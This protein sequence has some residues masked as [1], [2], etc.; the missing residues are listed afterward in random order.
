MGQGDRIEFSSG[1][2]LIEILRIDVLSPFHLKRFGVLT[3]SLG[4]IEPFV[5]KRAA[6]TA[7]DPS[8]DLVANR[9]FHHSPR[10]RR[11]K[12]HRLLCT[13]Q[14]LKLWMNRVVKIPK[15]FAAMSNQWTR[16]RLPGFF[17]D[18]NWTGNEKLVVRMHELNIRHSA[19]L[20]K[21]SARQALNFQ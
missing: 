21:N 6:H 3:A 5:R 1:Q 9:R 2:L 16:K 18:F 12:K 8:V 13:E 15:I 17:G 11:R 14:R 19:R 10:R 20:C 4:D 7:K